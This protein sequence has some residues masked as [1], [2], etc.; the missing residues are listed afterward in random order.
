M[1]LTSVGRTRCVSVDRQRVGPA[2]DLARAGEDDLRAGIV[3]AAR[4]EQRQLAAAVDLEIRVRIPHAVDVAHL[5]G[6]VED[7]VA[8]AHEVVHRALLADVGD[9]D[10]DAIG[11]AVDVE[12]VA[13]VVGDQRVDEQHVGAELDEPAREVAADEAEAAGDHHAAAAVELAVVGGHGAARGRCAIG[14]GGVATAPARRCWRRT[15]SANHRRITSTPVLKMR[16]KLK[17]CDLPNARW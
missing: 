8:V 11:D 16:R 13:A 2:V 14:V 4:L 5:A 7:D 15:T 6:E 10:A 17:N 12:Q 1:P 3:V 9:V